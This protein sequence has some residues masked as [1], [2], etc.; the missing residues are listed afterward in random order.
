M[1]N[2]LLRRFR[3]TLDYSRKLMV[4][5]PNRRLREPFGR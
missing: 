5:E 1:G 3:V 4:L 2:P